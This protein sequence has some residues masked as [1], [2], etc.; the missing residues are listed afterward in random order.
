MEYALRIEEPP[1]L[2]SDPRGW[3]EAR[4]RSAL[5]EGRLAALYFGTDFCEERLP[6]ISEVTRFC[7]A[8]REHGLEAVL[9]TPLVRPGGLRRL[10][11]LLEAVEASGAAV[12]VVFNDW[13]VLG[14]L[15]ERHPGLPRRGGRLLNRG[16][17]DPRIAGAWEAPDATRAAGERGRRLRGLLR[18]LGA[19]AV[20][21]DPDLEGGF[22]GDGSEGLQRA[23]HLPYVLA[24]SGRNCLSKAAA[25]RESRSLAVAFSAGCSRSCAEGARTEARSDAALPLRRAGNTLFYEAPAA[26]ALAHLGSADRI[27]LHRRPAP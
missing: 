16:L 9:L 14:L 12:S 11:Q 19:V 25:R 5:P 6:A 21:S 27:V 15:R 3:C 4:W 22:L 10:G 24:A 8:A 1:D 18:S 23:L 2:P 26:L 20:E 17:R 13:G 7:Q